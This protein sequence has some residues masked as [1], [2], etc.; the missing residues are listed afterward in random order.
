M[1]VGFHAWK[2]GVWCGHLQFFWRV[3]AVPYCTP[4]AA[5]GAWRV[6]ITVVLVMFGVTTSV[7]AVCVSSFGI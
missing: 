7:H 3:C 4:F 1:P 6:E 2:H 5:L